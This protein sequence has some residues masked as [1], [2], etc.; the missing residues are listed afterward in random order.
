M[1][2]VIEFRELRRNS[3]LGFAKIRVAEWHLVI[4]DVAIY[5]KDGRKW[6]RLPS[7]QLLDKNSGGLCAMPMAS[8]GTSDFYS[9][10]IERLATG[11][12]IAWFGL[13]RR[14]RQTGNSEWLR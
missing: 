5:E 6:A 13:S 9:S 14:I 10:M 11:S 4:S 2:E 1:I 7:K 3:L 12:A 8:P